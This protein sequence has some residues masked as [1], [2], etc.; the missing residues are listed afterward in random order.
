VVWLEEPYMPAEDFSFYGRS[1]RAAFTLLGIG[2]AAKGST[3][4]LHNPRFTMNEELMALGTALHV[5]LALEA[6]QALRHGAE[7]AEGAGSC[8]AL[9][10]EGASGCASS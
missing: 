5:G 3:V 6:L 8:S 1:A 10:A 4:G 7:R 9:G 2:D